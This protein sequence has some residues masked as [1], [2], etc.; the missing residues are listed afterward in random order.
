MAFSPACRGATAVLWT[1]GHSRPAVQWPDTM[2]LGKYDVLRRIATGGMAELHL[3]RM[4]GIEGFE[5]L[6]AV[7]RILPHLAGERAFVQMFLDEA[8]IA[9]TLH[10]T[11]VV[12]VFDI[13]EDG[14]TY[15]IAMEF[16]HGQDVRHLMAAAA[17]RRITIGMDHA[18]AIVLGACA[19]LHYAHE[20]RDADGQPLQIV[21]RDVSPQNLF[22][23]YDGAVKLV[24]FGIAKASARLSETRSG[25]IKGKLR[26][27]SPEQCCA[28]PLDRRSDIFSLCVL[29]WELTTGRRLFLRETELAIM[30]AIVDHDAPPPSSVV[31]DYPLEL[32]RIVMKGLR[33]DRAGRHGTAEELQIELEELA[34]EHKLAVTPLGVAKLMR[35]LYG[36]RIQGFL[37]AQREG[38]VSEFLVKTVG[39]QLEESVVVQM[40]GGPS[41]E[42]AVTKQ[43]LPTPHPH[44]TRGETESL[45]GTGAP[46]AD[47]AA[48]ANPAPSSQA[49]T[50]PI[51]ARPPRRR[52][53]AGGLAAGVVGALILATF[54][55]YWLLHTS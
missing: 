40:D 20:K 18:I 43:R 29:L 54:F 8:R 26:Y 13:G 48:G 44:P 34:R 3:A 6:V 50:V 25:V 35:E 7:K 2:R 53:A 46:P 19:G 12:Q 31:A 38:T 27:M 30:R 41:P 23:T 51:A 9:A 21:H 1:A 45:P 5:K 39:D 49:L 10:H 37:E 15:F 55:L 47:T 36:Q 33:R 11:N 52:V 24:D 22:V 42:S 14:G 4:S 17:A 28:E 16:L 32:E